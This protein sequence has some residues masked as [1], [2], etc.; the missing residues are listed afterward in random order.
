MTNGGSQY[1]KNYESKAKD[2]KYS[3]TPDDDLINDDGYFLNYVPTT[4]DPGNIMMIISIVYCTFFFFILPV[5]V[6]TGRKHY[7]RAM[8]AANVSDGE[9]S[10]SEEEESEE[11]EPKYRRNEIDPPRRYAPTS[12]GIRPT[13]QRP[14]QEREIS[15]RN[16][17]ATSRRQGGSCSRRNIYN[18]TGQCERWNNALQREYE[19]DA[20][21]P[22]GIQPMG[23]II[24]D[25]K[26]DLESPKR[27]FLDD[28]LDGNSRKRSMWDRRTAPIRT[29]STRR[30]F[31]QHPSS[32]NE[33]QY[34][35]A[36]KI[37][38]AGTKHLQRIGEDHDNDSHSDSSVKGKRSVV[39]L[40]AHFLNKE[41]L[42]EY[43]IDDPTICCGRGAIYSCDSLIEGI[44]YC[45][46]LSKCDSE[47]K[48]LFEISLPF[49]IGPIFT[50]FLDMLD[51]VIVVKYL[52]LETLTAYSIVG[53]VV[54]FGYSFFGGICS[55]CSTL[56]AHA[57]GSNN[58]FLAGQYVQLIWF[59]FI[60]STQIVMYKYEQY[61]EPL[62]RMLCN[63]D[64]VAALGLVVAKNVNFNYMLY[65]LL[66]IFEGL[67][68]NAEHEKFDSKLDA[69]ISCL[70]TL[71][72][73]ICLKY[74]DG[75]LPTIVRIWTYNYFLHMFIWMV[76]A[77]RKGW[78]QPFAR[79]IFGNFALS[80]C[81]A[82]GL[83]FKTALPLSISEVLSY[84]EWEVLLVFAAHL[85]EAEIPV[86][87]MVASIWEFLESTTSGLMEAVAIRVA[88][89]LGKG[90][91][92]LAR[93]SA[94]KALLYS[95]LI[96]CVTSI[97][98]C[99]IGETVPLWF[100]DVE[101][102]QDMIFETIPIMAVGNVF[103]VYGKY[104]EILFSLSRLLCFINGYPSVHYL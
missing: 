102:I 30:M 20:A 80:N 86:W 21:T 35:E 82:V 84:L 45:L 51:L 96:A 17:L 55:S 71:F 74:F 11:E 89:H 76:M 68:I 65:G 24:A 61:I 14:A 42:D 7:A 43:H 53:F 9:P 41:E 5:F 70:N 94:H 4:N 25:M 18:K 85:G 93:L 64:N 13:L 67:M 26:N 59:F 69:F 99:I 3:H 16:V 75:D 60:L 81:K 57:V 83:I 66:D 58:N 6:S 73:F 47:T 23:Q 87:S 8:V 90:R 79:G 39:K 2:N 33:M 31:G 46:Y 48:R 49:T 95:F 97:F 103:L 37:N 15:L 1:T 36:P 54:G 34:Q 63:N 29:N 91:P 40:A 19:T 27:T 22:F 10:E 12:Y 104:K 77:C 101:I 92:A 62:T 100:T 38:L 72:T 44:E 50:G 28:Y 98:V 56:T 78:I 88:L 52:G 32:L